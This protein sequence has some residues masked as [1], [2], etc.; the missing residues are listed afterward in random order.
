M[1]ITA[2]WVDPDDA[3]ELDTAWSEAATVKTSGKPIKGGRPRGSDKGQVS[4]R[5]DK[6]GG[7]PSAPAA[8]A[9]KPA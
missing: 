4:L 3:P 6:E 8:L 7:A 1:T 9:G 2:E 5:I